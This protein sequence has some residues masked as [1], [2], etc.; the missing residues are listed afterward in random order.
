MRCVMCEEVSGEMSEEV[1]G[2]ISEKVSGEIRD[3]CEEVRCVRK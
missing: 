2:E 3:M 1:S